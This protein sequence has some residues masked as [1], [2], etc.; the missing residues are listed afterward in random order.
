MIVRY[1][2]IGL[3]LLLG[4]A[5]CDRGE[6]PGCMRDGDCT[7]PYVC[8]LGVCLRYALDGGTPQDPDTGRA[9][10]AGASDG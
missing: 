3:L 9:S 2:T 1:R 10:E 6:A 7:A 5:A 4:L 8:R